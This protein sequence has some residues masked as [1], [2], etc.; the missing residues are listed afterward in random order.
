MNKKLRL[1]VTE[2][3]PNHCPMCC[4][5]QFKVEDIPVVD[6]WDYD[7]IMIT[8]G[9]PMLYPGHVKELCKSIRTV[10]KQMGINPKI[11]IYT[12]RCEFEFIEDAIRNYADGLVVT[13]YTANDI[14]FFRQLNNNLLKYRY[15]KF[16]ECSLRLN[17]FPEVKDALPENLKCW[18]VKEMQWIENCPVPEGEDFRRVAEF[19][20]DN[21]W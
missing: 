18:Q 16:L 10:T 12:S 21:I 8:G 9:E 5:K 7:E 6:R 20:T 1:M 15:G 17:V 3:C 14:K 4:N 11:Y 13:P 19:F 2:N